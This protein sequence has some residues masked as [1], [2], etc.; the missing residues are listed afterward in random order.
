MV[1]VELAQEVR[2]QLLLCQWLVKTSLAWYT[3]LF[4]YKSLKSNQSFGVEIPLTFVVVL[5][6]LFEED[7][8]QFCLLLQSDPLLVWKY[9]YISKYSTSCFTLA[10]CRWRCFSSMNMCAHIQNI[11]LA[12]SI[13]RWMKSYDRTFQLRRERPVLNQYIVTCSL[14]LDLK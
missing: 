14:Y 12:S 2:T 8:H 9:I 4:H 7:V 3:I 6:C 10:N 5:S 1:V 13:R 11:T